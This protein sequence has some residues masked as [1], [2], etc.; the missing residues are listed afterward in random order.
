MPFMTV[1]YNLRDY[2]FCLP[3]A[4]SL[5][6]DALETALSTYFHMR[7]LMTIT[8]STLYCS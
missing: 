5:Q 4:F 1:C 2:S 3:V 7:C 6:N 8:V